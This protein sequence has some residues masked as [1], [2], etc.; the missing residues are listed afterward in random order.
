MKNLPPKLPLLCIVAII[1]GIYSCKKSKF[2]GSEKT[3]E[4]TKTS[5]EYF[6][7]STQA[8][9]KVDMVIAMDTSASMKDEKEGLERNIEIFF[10]ELEKRGI[11]L[12]I[13]AMGSDEGSDNN[14]GFAFPSSLP[15]NKFQVVDRPINSDNA[16]KV[17]TEFY[18]DGD[19]PLPFRKDA[20]HEVVII[21]DDN[22]NMDGGYAKDF[23]PLTGYKT[24]VNA[25]VGLEEIDNEHCK[26]DSVGEEHMTL[27][28]QTGGLILDLCNKDWNDLIK[29]LAASIGDRAGAEYTIKGNIDTTRPLKV[30]IDSRVVSQSD[31]TFN[32]SSKKI[33]FRIPVEE[34]ARIAVE[35]ITKA[36]Q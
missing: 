30:T 6:T 2:A 7:G 5:V 16:I 20:S 4:E 34:G 36:A 12:H 25:I 1:F 8:T 28:R 18:R 19:F 26:I 17:L 21:S 24:T 9:A 29:K 13:T 14:S 22:G 33:V 15:K 27:A 35:Y 23:K 10:E 3:V 32:T 11:D 31:Y